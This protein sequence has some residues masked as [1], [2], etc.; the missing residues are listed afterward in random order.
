MKHV[1]LCTGTPAM[2]RP[3][4]LFPL[5]QI[6]RPDVFKFFREYGNRY[7]DPQQSKYHKGIEYEGSTNSKELHFILKKCIMIRRY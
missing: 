2:A 7:C 6:I 4:E 5:I 3:K 1:I